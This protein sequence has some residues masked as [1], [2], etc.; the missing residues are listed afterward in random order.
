LSENSAW[1]FTFVDVMAAS[2]GTRAEAPMA[3]PSTDRCSLPEN[4]SSADFFFPL[5]TIPAQR[6]PDGRDFFAAEDTFRSIAA[7]RS[8]TVAALIGKPVLSLPIELLVVDRL[9]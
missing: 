7:L 5:H 3:K 9:A 8:L 2:L 6:T 4:G 1:I